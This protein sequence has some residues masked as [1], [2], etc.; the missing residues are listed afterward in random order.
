[1]KGHFASYYRIV[2]FCLL[3]FSITGNAV[4]VFDSAR[5]RELLSELKHE[6][7][8]TLRETSQSLDELDEISNRWARVEY[9]RQE[10]ADRAR[11]L[12]VWDLI[13]EH[14]GTQPPVVLRRA[15]EMAAQGE[16]PGGKTF[17]QAYPLS[18]S[19]LR[20]SPPKD[21]AE[22]KRLRVI[23]SLSYLLAESRHETSTLFLDHENNSRALSAFPKAELM[24]MRRKSLDL[25]KEKL[26]DFKPFADLLAKDGDDETEQSYFQESAKRILDAPQVPQSIKDQIS[27]ELNFESKYGYPTHPFLKEMLN[28]VSKHYG[29]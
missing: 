23:L 29:I 24:K 10:S 27:I 16:M 19:F 21:Q 18:S 1:M 20:E 25:L 9:L 6:Y 11:E 3:S 8:S 28:A 14:A 26:S 5:C 17:E 2:W 12:D 13:E 4:G 22:A 15:A 7:L